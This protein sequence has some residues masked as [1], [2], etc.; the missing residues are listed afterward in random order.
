MS[1]DLE[2]DD[3]VK[4]SAEKFVKDLKE[5]LYYSPEWGEMSFTKPRPQKPRSK[6]WKEFKAFFDPGMLGYMSA[7]WAFVLVGSLVFWTLFA[8]VRWILF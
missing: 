2:V 3:D 8:F 5:G 1:V 4:E 7:V 6:F